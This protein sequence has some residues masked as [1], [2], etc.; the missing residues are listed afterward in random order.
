MIK[1]SKVLLFNPRSANFKYRLPNSLLAVAASIDNEFEWVVVDGNRENDPEKKILDYLITGEFAFFGLTVMPGPQL[2]QAIPISKKAKTLFP[3]LTIIWGGYFASNQ[4]ETVLNSGFVDFVINGMGDKVFPELLHQILKDGNHFYKKITS[5]QIPHNLIYKNQNEIVFTAKDGIYNP[6]ELPDFPY[7]KLHKLYDIPK[8]LGK[9]YLGGKTIAYHSSFGCP[10]TCSFCAVVPIYNARW[11]GK[12]ASNI[13][14]EIK[15]LKDNF[16]GDSIEFHDNNFFVSEKRTVEFSELIMNDNMI[17]WG[18]G[19]IDTI[20]KYS[21]ASLEK[22]RKSGCKMIFFGAE[23]G[24]DEMLKQ[25]DKGGTQSAAQIKK[26][27]ARMAKFDIIPEYSFVLGTPAD[28]PEK[29]MEQIDKDI[30]F[31]R[32]IKEINPATEIIIYVYSPVPTKGSE[33]YEKV[34]A[35]GFRFPEKLEDWVSADWEN[36]DLR[37]NPLTPWLTP[38]MVDKIKNFET[39]LNGYYPTA[40]DIKISK[41][42]KSTVRTLSA[43]RYHTKFYHYPYEIKALQKFW[44][45]YRQPEIQG[46]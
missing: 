25:M 46:F 39:V 36:F 45:N 8:Y 20:D 9:T 34:L 31:I 3:N 28:T 13:Y 18:E 16:G 12:S 23:T 26:F 6:D 15:Y 24:N 7:T 44:L 14:R 38:A 29:V 42:Q 11:K 4:P 43:I 37:K 32:E 33:L 21:D 30:A 41:F 5:A 2:K 35:T 40:T 17:W 1:K 27:A 10:F 22:M 19:R